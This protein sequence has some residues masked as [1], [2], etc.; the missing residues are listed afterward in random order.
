MSTKKRSIQKQDYNRVLVTETLPYETP[1]VFSNEGLYRNSRQLKTAGVVLQRLFEGLVLTLPGKDNWRLPYS[2]KIHKSNTDFRRLSLIH[3][4]SQWDIRQFY[5]ANAELILYYCSRSEFSIR[6]PFKI[7]SLLFRKNSESIV[8]RYKDKAIAELERDIVIQ[9]SPSFYAYRGYDRLHKFFESTQLCELEKRFKC[10]WMLD[11]SKCFDS[12]YTHTMS[13]AVKDK[14]FAKANTN[15]ESTFGQTFDL[16]MQRANHGETNGIVIGPEASR[17]FAEII[18]QAIDKS[19]QAS[20]EN[21]KESFIHE[22]HYAVRRYVDD[23]YI[24][25][26]DEEGAQRVYEKYGDALSRF[27]LHIN[28]TKTRRTKRPFITDKSRAI[29]QA[30]LCVNEFIESFCEKLAGTNRLVPKK[31]RHPNK[32]TQSFIA[33][34]REMCSVGASGY[35]EVA[36]YLIA[37]LVERVKGI[38]NV[39]GAQPLGLEASNYADAVGVILE[40]LFFLYSVSPAVSSSYR[41]STAIVLINRLS[42]K[43]LGNYALVIKQAIYDLT[44]QLLSSENIVKM[45]VTG[46]VSL[47]AVNI[48]LASSD[49]GDAYLLPETQV[50]NLFQRSGSANLATRYS[51]FEIVSCLFYI[52]DYPQYERLREDILKDVKEY[53]NDLSDIQKNTEKTLLFLDILCCPYLELQL[54]EKLLLRFYQQTQ[55]GYAI[56]PNDMVEFFASCGEQFWF[57]KWQKVDILNSL[58]KKQLRKVY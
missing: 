11:V 43:C 13:W 49:L 34:C 30:S 52:K 19:A 27:N 32:L 35:D 45:Q 18:F 56:C 25:A 37:V 46:F 40:V 39:N 42:Q 7:G 22:E 4:K 14:E 1:I 31:I 47:E 3:P 36:A 12:I 23:I 2:Y 57:V 10:L 8:N 50:M 48:L 28:D 51:Y 15:V 53:L 9:Y 55:Q 41:L 16:I 54:R 20:L 24:F 44:E 17:I 58:E 38:A 5:E 21:V 29:R 33:S 6:A 26:R